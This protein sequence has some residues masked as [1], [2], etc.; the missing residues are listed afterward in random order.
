MTES[1]YP[2][3]YVLVTRFF[4]EL[5]AGPAGNKLGKADNNGRKILATDVMSKFGE[6]EIND[7]LWRVPAV[8][9]TGLGGLEVATFTEFA[10][11]DRHKHGVSTEIYTVLKGTMLIYINDEGPHELNAMDEVIIFPGTI[12]EVVQKKRRARDPGE[13]FELLV[14]VHALNCH[15]VDDKFVQLAPNDE[16][17]CWSKLSVEDRKRAYKKQI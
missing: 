3:P 4:V 2:V 14:R 8:L 11:Q 7:P 10:G 13:G 5:D 16:W 9:P 15:G 12:H 1:P 17:H 6:V